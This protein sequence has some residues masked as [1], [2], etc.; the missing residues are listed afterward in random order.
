M[1]EAAAAAAPRERALRAH[2]R[3]ARRLII[4]D[5]IHVILAADFSFAAATFAIYT[6]PD[7]RPC[8][9]AFPERPSS[10]PDGARAVPRTAAQQTE[11]AL[12]LS[13][14]RGGAGTAVASAASSA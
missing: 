5:S 14:S 2:T 13:A 1:A 7:D 3:H 11:A 10:S 4:I 9:G 6:F 12:F 8:S